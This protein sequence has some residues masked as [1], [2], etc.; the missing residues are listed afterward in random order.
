MPVH[1]DYQVCYNNARVWQKWY[2]NIGGTSY[3]SLTNHGNFKGN[4]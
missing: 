1:A 3:G 2:H 4:K